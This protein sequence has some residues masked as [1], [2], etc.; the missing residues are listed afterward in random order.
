MKTFVLLAAL[1]AMGCA[2][3]GAV[4]LCSPPPPPAPRQAT[5][6]DAIASAEQAWAH[7]AD[8]ERLREAISHWRDAVALAPERPDL[9]LRLAAALYLRADGTLRLSGKAEDMIAAFKEATETAEAALRLGNPRFAE[10]VCKEQPFD[11]A[12]GMLRAED[13]PAIYEYATAIGQ[14][15][16]ARSVIGVLDRKDRVRAVMER[17]HR[18]APDFHFGAL[19]LYLGAYYTK[20]PFP[21]GD[22]AKARRHFDRAVRAGPGF[23]ATR[24]LRAELLAPLLGDAAL[25]RSDLEAVLAAP[26][27]VVP[28]LEP[29]NA[30]A[31][32]RAEAL[33]GDEALLFPSIHA[34]RRP[35]EPAEASWF[36]RS[37]G[38]ATSGPLDGHAMRLLRTG[39]Q[40]DVERFR[41]LRNAKRSV[42]VVAYAWKN[43]NVGLSLVNAICDRIRETH[44][45]LEVKIILENFGSK[46][47]YQGTREPL[48][49]GDDL[50]SDNRVRPPGAETLHRCGAEVVFYHPYREEL[51]HLFQARHEK[52]LI[53]DGERVLTGGSN[54]GDHYHMAS[55][56]SGKWYDLD[57]S[58]AGPVACWYHNEFQRSWRRVV[59]QD[60]GL[61]PDGP[62]RPGIGVRSYGMG[63]MTSC[64]VSAA[65]RFGSARVHA[66]IGRPAETAARPILDAHIGSVNEARR[67]IR[68]NAP[69]FVA[70]DAYLH[71]L[72]EAR[73]RGVPV[74][75]IT[76]SVE[77]LD[78]DDL[79]FTAMVLSTL[80]DPDGDGPDGA[81][82]D[83]GVD[84]RLWKRKAT[85]HRKGGI[86]DAGLA[87]EKVYLG[88]D[89]V[90]VR[91]QEFSTEA[92]TWTDDSEIVALMAGDF[93]RDLGSTVR[94]T[95]EMAEA[96]IAQQRE[97]AWGRLKLS[98][99]EDL[100]ALF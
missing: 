14:Y 35:P 5:L 29:E 97:T 61:D 41:L 42:Y 57:V 7:R 59:S 3:T 20:V 16:L 65:R 13:V 98:I 37:P 85:F 6:D 44:G 43:D 89:N 76:N 63:R 78:E 73:R 10:A 18:L 19:D 28:G 52:L 17:A 96:W 31:K 67:S 49:E 81:L 45:R 75:V 88:S 71:T 40:V 47:L 80:R 12:V 84:V 39:E 27:D 26:L 21:T 36:F 48:R 87:G 8:D 30:V 15:G 94:L 72:I 32:R 55:P 56:R 74:T 95:R 34:A 99:A 79:I 11:Q 22:L 64:D 53:V 24:V 51:R 25:F 77:S 86:F 83:Q 62:P 50:F 2:T 60:I 58:I 93:D 66:L 69:Y 91:G 54:I 70:P 92:V 33:L 46:E 1:L 38:G 68:L 23:L 9:R 4:S 90:D 100:R 82:I